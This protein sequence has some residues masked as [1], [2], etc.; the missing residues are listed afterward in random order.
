MIHSLIKTIQAADV[1][2]PQEVLDWARWY[3]M[4]YHER[5]KEMQRGKKLR[6]RR[7]DA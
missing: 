3:E 1:A 5:E 4:N 6:I 2:L 7:G